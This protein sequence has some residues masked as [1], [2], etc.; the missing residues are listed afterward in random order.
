MEDES[1]PGSAVVLIVGFLMVAIGWMVAAGSMD[2]GTAN[3][4]RGL[5]W[6]GGAIFSLGILIEFFSMGS[7]LRKISKLLAESH[8]PSDAAD[9]TDGRSEGINKDS[10]A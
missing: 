2:V 8:G 1:V 6:L 7:S 3:M 5:E 10:Q 4:G 9:P